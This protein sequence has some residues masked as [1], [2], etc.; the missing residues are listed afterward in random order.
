MTTLSISLTL[1]LIAILTLLLLPLAKRFKQN[2]NITLFMVL[3]LPTISLGGYFWLGTPQFAEMS[4]VQA[5]PEQVSL[6]D[7]LRQKLAKNPKDIEGWIL[8]GR[9]AMIE[10]D[11]LQAVNAFEKA[12]K[13]DSNRVDVLVPLADAIAVT[14]HGSLNGRPYDLLKSAY[15]RFPNHLMT[16]WLLGMAE[17]QQ[18]N[19]MLAALYWQKAYAIVPQGHPDQQVL[20]DLLAS[21]GSQPDPNL[22]IPV[23]KIEKEPVQEVKSN[24]KDPEFFIESKLLNQYPMA[25]I[26][27][28]VQ[29]INGMPMPIAAKKLTFSELGNRVTIN[30]TDEI[31]PARTLSQFTK[32]KVSLKISLSDDAFADKNNTVFQQSI[33]V[34]N[35]NSKAITVN[36][37]YN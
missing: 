18:K 10:K 21:V 2:K 37:K 26:F 11:Y 16:L 9:S 5:K 17:S 3:I 4:T 22:T 28:A 19:P 31:M 15:K 23:N 25:T 6:V 32:V 13:L 36:I 8:L 33:E 20:K 27:L 35:N 30:S 12:Y 1:I 29:E 34:A 24:N 14:Q 7:N